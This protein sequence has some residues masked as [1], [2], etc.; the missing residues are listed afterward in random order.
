MRFSVFVLI[1]ALSI[2]FTGCRKDFDINHSSLDFSV[3]QDTIFIGTVFQGIKSPVYSLMIKNNSKSDILIPSVSLENKPSKIMLNI[4]GKSSQQFEN[5]IL[6]KNDS[7]R[8]FINI[9]FENISKNHLYEDNIIF[10]SLNNKSKKIK[11]YSF[12]EKAKVYFDKSDLNFQNNYAFLDNS[13]VHIFYNSLEIPENSTLEIKK[14][15]H[16]RFF[17]KAGIELNKGS[18]LNIDGDAKNKVILQGFRTEPRYDSLPG[19]W[20]GIISN[21]GNIRLNHTTIKGAKT[22]IKADNS[23]LSIDKSS[24]INSSLYGVNAHKSELNLF[25]SIIFNAGKTALLVNTPSVS[26]IIFSTIANPWETNISGTSGL[27]YCLELEN[28]SNQN[29]EVINSIFYGRSDNGVQIPSGDFSN[30]SFNHVLIKNKNK[31]ELN[32][33]NSN[34]FKNTIT[35]NPLFK[36]TSFSNPNLSIKENSPAK[37]KGIFLDNF[38]KDINDNKRDASPSLGAYR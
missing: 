31:T 23:V 18:F 30:L 22:G 6:L 2:V 11:I 16:L 38:S 7:V 12:L 14:G 3:S 21:Q 37:N 4:N 15:T 20:N 27:N 34:I 26:K 25:N 8:I 1:S 24:I 32:L 9:G 17:N 5:I 28:Y 19:Q 29:F 36:S 33:S 13:M 10:S 35:E